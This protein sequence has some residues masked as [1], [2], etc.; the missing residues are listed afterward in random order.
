[1][2]SA[3]LVA[4]GEDSFHAEDAKVGAEFR[5]ENFS[6]ATLGAALSVESGGL[7]LWLR[8]RRAM[9]LRLL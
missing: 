4:F 2:L 9:L 5:S 3:N 8:F 7:P 6:F 1:V